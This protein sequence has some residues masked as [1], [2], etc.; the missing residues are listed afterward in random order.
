MRQVHIL[1][2]SFFLAMAGCSSGGSV[3]DP[4]LKISRVYCDGADNPVCDNTGPRFGWMLSG[5]GYGRMQSAYRILVASS[6]RLL[7]DERADIWDSG[8]ILSD[9]SQWIACPDRDLKSGERYFWRV[10]VWDEKDIPSEYSETAW[11]FVPGG[12]DATDAEWISDR[13]EDGPDPGTSVAPLF[14]KSFSLDKKP[15]KAILRYT[16]AGYV[17]MFANGRE[18]SGA[19]LQPSFTRYDRRMEYMTED[20]T[21]LLQAGENVLGCMAGNG[22]YNVDTRS[23]WNFRNAPWRARPAVICRLELTLDDGKKIGIVTD[24]GW[25]TSPGPVTFNQVRN[26]ESYDARLDQA[27][28]KEAGFDDSGW[29]SAVPVTGPAGKLSPAIIPP[30]R[31]LGILTAEKITE[32]EPGV[33]LFDFGQNIAG[34]TK[35][36]VTGKAGDEI[37]IRHGERIDSAGRLDQVEL[38]RFIFTG[39]TQT[40]RYTLKD[41]HSAT[42]EPSFTWYGFRYAEV[43]GLKYRP[44]TATLKACIVS[45]DLDTTGYLL[46]G[47]DIIDRLHTNTMWSYL[48]NFH[49]IPEDCPHR[50]K[51]GWT[52]DGQLAAGTGMLNFYA[53]NAYRKWL[54]D[55]TDEQKENGDLPG[56][57]PTSGWGYNYGREPVKGKYGYGPQWDGA[58]IT[59]PWKLFEYYGDTAVLKRYYLMMDRYMAWLATAADGDLPDIGIDDHKSLVESDPATVSSAWYYILSATMARIARVT[60]HIADVG[61]YS[62]LRDSLASK[63][64]EKYFPGGVPG[65][66]SFLSIALAAGSD[67]L[68]PQ[69]EDVFMKVMVQKIK[70]DGYHVSTGVI[71]T[72]AVFSAL[73]RKGYPDVFIRLVT[74]P[75]F[76]SYGNWVKKGATTLWQ[77]WDGSQSR[78]HIMFGF[79][80]EYM[81]D[82]FLGLANISP[83]FGRFTLAPVFPDGSDE[84]TACHTSLYG[85]I[86]S[87]WKRENDKIS[88]SITV[89]VNTTSTIFFPAGATAI[90]TDLPDKGKPAIRGRAGAYTANAGSGSY[91]FVFLLKK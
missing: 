7:Q 28:W 79:V 51:M 82:V 72:N 48:G 77:N 30:I 47:N 60:G 56:I 26:G 45:T 22:F 89:P 76:P 11:F 65:N 41:D 84:V 46:T 67:M 25:K 71:G 64:I 32:P 74:N 61:K 19:V 80:D 59:I 42:W 31:R 85:E 3:N 83:G 8:K 15:V 87:S 6:E 44:D 14:R 16:G 43:T 86:T 69:M 21:K 18:I 90:K 9:R 78:N 34:W 63:Y 36:F 2:L 52:G 55:F 62:G 49:S 66:A 29:K 88:W 35:L 54:D 5:E 68:P 81:Y 57:I 53:Y 17:R 58:C 13:P 73:V 91:R 23:A 33:W 27:G 12:L 24:G 75:E 4:P 37:V 50:E 70:A 40:S 20:I 10:M 1:I 38:S 39:E